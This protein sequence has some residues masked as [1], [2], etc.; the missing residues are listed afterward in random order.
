MNDFE[1]FRIVT[2][3]N[4]TTGAIH[5]TIR[6]HKKALED[7]GYEEFIGDPAQMKKYAHLNNDGVKPVSHEEA[8]KIAQRF[9]DGYFGN[10]ERCDW[11]TASIPANPHTDD[12]LRLMMYISQCQEDNQQALALALYEELNWKAQDKI[13]A[14]AEALRMCKNSD[15]LGMI[16]ITASAALEKAGLP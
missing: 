16:R 8:R 15:F 13:N 12:D 3:V 2:M 6:L 11:P 5:D 10:G 7:N 9:I 4:K 14:L 1:K